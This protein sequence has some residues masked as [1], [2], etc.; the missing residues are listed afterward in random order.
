MAVYVDP[1][2][3]HGWKYGA[4]CHMF[5]DSEEELIRFATNMGMRAEWIQRTRFIHFDLTERWRANAVRCGAIEIDGAELWRLRKK[6]TNPN[7]IR[8][9]R[10][11]H[12]QNEKG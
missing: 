4:S 7:Y 8:P 5:A 2:M 12:G 3:N 10:R 11:H 6:F 9:K 1:L